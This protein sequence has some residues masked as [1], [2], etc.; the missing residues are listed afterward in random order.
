M[1]ELM[2]SMR[3]MAGDTHCNPGA[4]EYWGS[5]DQASQLGQP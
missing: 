2:N 4:C 1:Y 3:V 5:G